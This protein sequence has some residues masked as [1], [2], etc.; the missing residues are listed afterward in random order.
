MRCTRVKVCCIQNVDEARCAVGAGADAL[1]LVGAMPSGPGV[2]A[3][4]TARAIAM[5]TA[6]PVM[7]ILLTSQ[8]T[9][10]GVAAHVDRVAPSAVQIV[11]HIDPAEHERLNA[12]APMRGVKRIQV[13]HVEGG[14]ALDLIDAYAP[15]VDAFLLDSGRPSA[16]RPE[17][18]GTG[19]T[20]DWDVSAT[21]V[22]ASPRP[23]FLAGGLNADNV[24]RAIDQVRPFGVDLCSGVR[25]ERGLDAAAL[26]AFMKAVRAADQR[27]SSPVAA[28]TPA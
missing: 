1:G 26:N 23:V 4:E 27:L 24:A 6:P 13:I 21:F 12:I 16:A 7:A 22:Q 8:T 2:I 14:D 3:D 19:R 25:G 10:D 5:A 28:F 20:H 17:L 11:A 18:G 15:H 9:A